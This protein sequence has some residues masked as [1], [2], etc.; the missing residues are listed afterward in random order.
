MD[1]DARPPAVSSR[2]DGR[3]GSP[4]SMRAWTCVHCAPARTV[5]YVPSVAPRSTP[6]PRAGDQVL[7]DLVVAVEHAARRLPDHAVQRPEPHAGLVQRLV[8]LAEEVRVLPDLRFRQPL[9]AQPVEPRLAVLDQHV[10]DVV[11]LEIA[12]EP[13][14]EAQVV[15]SPELLARRDHHRARSLVAHDAVVHALEV[16]AAVDA[17]QVGADLFLGQRLVGLGLAPARAAPRDWSAPGPRSGS[18]RPCRARCVSR[19]ASRAAPRTAPAAGC[20]ATA[21]R[22]ACASPP[23]R[24]GSRPSSA[25]SWPPRCRP[26]RARSARRRY[27]CS[28]TAGRPSACPGS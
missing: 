6:G 5:P 10:E 11:A 15:R 22:P 24:C 3:T 1:E 7:R 4:V 25:R 17:A 13:Q 23:R 19:P 18:R 9:A 20:S 26:G 16:A 27:P 12:R 14:A 28:S 21:T 2:T 8:E